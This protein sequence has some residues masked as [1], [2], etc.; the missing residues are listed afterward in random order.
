MHNIQCHAL[1]YI[2]IQ[3]HTLTYNNSMV[4]YDIAIPQRSNIFFKCKQSHRYVSQSVITL[5]GITISNHT[6][7]YH[8]QYSR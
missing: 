5:I 1:T 7:L 6:D 2:N 8:N 3:Y 4:M